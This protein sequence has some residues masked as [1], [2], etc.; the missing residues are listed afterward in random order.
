[1][2]H[3]MKG[4]ITPVIGEGLPEVE[5]LV[6]PRKTGNIYDP[7]HPQEPKWRNA[8][9]TEMKRVRDWGV[10]INDGIYHRH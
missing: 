9:C 8:I 5:N 2:T 3:S 4:V 10:Y 7:Y 1:M 6:E